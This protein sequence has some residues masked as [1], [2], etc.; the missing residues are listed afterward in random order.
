MGIKIVWKFILE[1]MNGSIINKYSFF[2]T[3]IVSLRPYLIFELAFV[4]EE[5]VRQN[6]FYLKYALEITVLF[7]NSDIVPSSTC[8]VNRKKTS[9]RILYVDI[10]VKENVIIFMYSLQHVWKVVSCYVTYVYISICILLASAGVNL[11]TT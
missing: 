11:I 9:N 4:R 6:H 7:S 3:H 1:G 5:L 2:F 10:K 8:F